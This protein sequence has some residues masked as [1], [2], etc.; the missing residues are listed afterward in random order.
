MNRKLK[1]GKRETRE[2]Y[3]QHYQRGGQISQ[4][5]KKIHHDLCFFIGEPKTAMWWVRGC[6]SGNIP[7]QLVFHVPWVQRS[8]KV[9]VSGMCQLNVGHLKQNQGIT[10]LLAP[11]PLHWPSTNSWCDS[12]L[13][14][15]AHGT[16]L[17]FRIPSMMKH[18]FQGCSG[19][20]M[21]NLLITPFITQCHFTM[22]SKQTTKIPV[23]DSIQPEVT[24]DRYHLKKYIYPLGKYYF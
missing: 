17:Y 10:L 19:T 13:P 11:E 7:R 16:C 4:I 18:G 6:S 20:K 21:Y 9:L 15:L 8:G 5:E 22:F 2:I 23:S 3:I 12:A 14:G 1:Q 24:R